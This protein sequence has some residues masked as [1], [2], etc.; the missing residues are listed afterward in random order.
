MF[1]IATKHRENVGVLKEHRDLTDAIL[2]LPWI[3]ERRPSIVWF[4]CFHSSKPRPYQIAVE[5]ECGALLKADAGY[6]QY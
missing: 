6:R 3:A 2:I 4:I 5:F 1:F